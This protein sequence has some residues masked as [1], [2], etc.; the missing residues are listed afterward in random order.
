MRVSKNILPQKRGK[1]GPKNGFFENTPHTS[2]KTPNMGGG[3]PPIPGS[4]KR[5]IEEFLISINHVK[6]YGQNE[7]R[8]IGSFCWDKTKKLRFLEIK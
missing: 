6:S 8:K 5:Y 2:L 7:F 3:P 1:K 4:L